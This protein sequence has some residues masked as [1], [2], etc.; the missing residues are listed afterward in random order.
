M[1]SSSLSQE[2][3]DHDPSVLTRR[4]KVKIANRNRSTFSK[5]ESIETTD[6]HELV[7]VKVEDLIAGEHMLSMSPGSL[8]YDHESP[9]RAVKLKDK[10]WPGHLHKNKPILK[11]KRKLRE[12]R[13]SSGVVHVQSTESSADSFD[14]SE[15]APISRDNPAQTTQAVQPAVTSTLAAC[16]SSDS[17][18]FLAG[19]MHN[20][21]IDA[22][23]PQTPEEDRKMFSGRTVRNKSP[24][25]L[26]AD[27]EDNQDY[28]STV[29]QP[30]VGCSRTSSSTRF[31]TLPAFPP[32]SSS[33]PSSSNSSASCNTGMYNTST[34]STSALH[35]T[36]ACSLIRG[37]K[38]DS[39]VVHFAATDTTV[40]EVHIVLY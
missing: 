9:N 24:S 31:P 4:I 22:D 26:D 18:K 29:S 20:E 1:A 38:P 40:E 5:H 19:M 2:S 13:R 7:D 11:D 21:I 28:D 6:D 8:F 12:K 10:R 36:E 37:G 23:N 3:L 14:E 34:I 17:Q 39:T 30:D 27:L 16:D 32:S 35:H 15:P 25:D 33:S